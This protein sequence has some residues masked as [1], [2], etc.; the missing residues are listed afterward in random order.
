MELSA[1]A[2]PMKMKHPNEEEEEPPRG[3]SRKKIIEEYAN[4]LRELIKVMRKRVS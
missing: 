2:F 4:S 1:G 3:E